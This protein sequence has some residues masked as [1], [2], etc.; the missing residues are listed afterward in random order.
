MQRQLLQFTVSES[1]NVF[2]TL[3]R[4]ALWLAEQILQ[5]PMEDI[6]VLT[7]QLVENFNMASKFGL[8]KQLGS[9]YG[10]GVV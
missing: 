7:G 5:L 4:Q 9:G 8:M 10:S 6:L 2:K 1:A 3:V